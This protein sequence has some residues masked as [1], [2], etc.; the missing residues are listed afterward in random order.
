[1]TD[2]REQILNSLFTVLQSV[3]GVQ[4]CVRNRDQMPDGKRPAILLLDGDEEARRDSDQRQRI[5]AAPNLVTL[6]PEIYFALE[7]RKPQ[8]DQVGEDSNAI[9]AKILKA[10]LNDQ[11][12]TGLCQNVFYTGCISDLAKGRE[13][14]GQMGLAIEFTYYLKPAEL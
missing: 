1:M 13:M 9:R 14:Q 10:V 12:L 7:N 2:K 11:S 8:N 6:K 5:A 4:S 3:D